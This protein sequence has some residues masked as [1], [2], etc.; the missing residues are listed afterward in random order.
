MNRKITYSILLLLSITI[1]SCTAEFQ[2]YSLDDNYAVSLHYNQKNSNESGDVP[3]KPGVLA[4]KYR[5][6]NLIDAGIWWAMKGIS[7]KK[8]NGLLVKTENNSTNQVPFGVTF[9]PLDFIKEKVAIKVRAKLFESNLDEV[10]LQLQLQDG[11]GY[12][13]NAAPP[14]IIIDD[15][16]QFKDYYFLIDDIFL[17]KKPEKR[18]VSGQFISILQ[19]M[20]N[21]E[22]EVFNGRI[23]IEEM[24]VIPSSMIK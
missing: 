22:E 6:G 7:L 9:P 24:K 17:Q 8:E 19:F 14:T 16:D 20:I 4:V 15:K 10:K 3:L 21:P 23:Q 18:E 2:T 11:N 5:E 13:T 1:I 12:L